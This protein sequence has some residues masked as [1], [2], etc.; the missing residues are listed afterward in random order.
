M[1]VSFAIVLTL[2]LFAPLYPVAAQTGV[3]RLDVST[4]WTNYRMDQTQVS[5]LNTTLG[6]TATG[7]GFSPGYT[8]VLDQQNCPNGWFSW[9]DPFAHDLVATARGSLTL[10][11]TY[12]DVDWRE[13]DGAPATS[14][15]T[16]LSSSTGYGTPVSLLGYSYQ[17]EYQS[18]TTT[19]YYYFL[20]AAT[21]DGWFDVDNYPTVFEQNGQVVHRD[22]IVWTRPTISNELVPFLFKNDEGPNAVLI[23]EY[24]GRA[25]DPYVGSA[26]PDRTDIGAVVL[27]LPH[28]N[29]EAIYVAYV[30][31][32]PRTA[33]VQGTW[34]V[35]YEDGTYTQLT[36]DLQDWCLKSVAPDRYFPGPLWGPVIGGP[37]RVSVSGT[38]QDIWTHVYA[39]KI[40]VN[41]GKT[42]DELVLYLGGLRG[43]DVDCY[44]YMIA[45]TIETAPGQ[46]LLVTGPNTYYVVSQAQLL[47]LSVSIPS[48]TFDATTSSFQIPSMTFSVTRGENVYISTFNVSFYAVYA[49]TTYEPVDVTSY[50]TVNGSQITDTLLST[51][52]SAL[53]NQGYYTFQNVTVPLE[54]NQPPV[55]IVA[56]VK[57]QIVVNGTV[58][59]VVGV[60]REEVLFTQSPLV[61]VSATAYQTSWSYDNG[62]AECGLDVQVSWQL[63]TSVSAYV[64]SVSVLVVDSAG[65]VVAEKCEYTTDPETSPLQ[66]PLTISI[67]T[68]PDTPS[69]LGQLTVYVRVS[70]SYGY[71]YDLQPQTVTVRYLIP[72]VKAQTEISGQTAEVSGVTVDLSINL[73]QTQNPGSYFT[74]FQTQVIVGTTTLTPSLTDFSWSYDQTSGEWV[75]TYTWQPSSPIATNSISVTVNATGSDGISYTVTYTYPTTRLLTL[76][77]ISLGVSA[78]GGITGWV[79]LQV[80][81]SA[82]GTLSATVNGNPASLIEVSSGQYTPVSS[83]V[84]YSGS[85]VDVIIQVPVGDDMVYLKFQT[86]YGVQTYPIAIHVPSLT[87]S[88]DVYEVYYS[89]TGYLFYYSVSSQDSTMTVDLYDDGTVDASANALQG[90]TVTLTLEDVSSGASYSVTLQG[91]TGTFTVPPDTFPGP[92]GVLQYTVQV[93]SQYLESYDGTPTPLTYQDETPYSELSWTY[94]GYYITVFLDTINDVMVAQAVPEQDLSVKG[95]YYVSGVDWIYH[96]GDDLVLYEGSEGYDVVTVSAT[97][98]GSTVQVSLTPVTFTSYG[99]KETDVSSNTTVPVTVITIPYSGTTY[100]VDAWGS[101]TSTQ[102][103]TLTFGTTQTVSSAGPLVI[104]DGQPSYLA[105]PGGFASVPYAVD[106]M[107][108]TTP[109]SSS[110]VV[111]GAALASGSYSAFWVNVGAGVMTYLPV[112]GYQFSG[113]YYEKNASL[114]VLVFSSATSQLYL[115]VDTDGEFFEP[116]WTTSEYQWGGMEYENV[117]DEEV[118]PSN[119]GETVVVVVEAEGGTPVAA[120]LV[121]GSPVKPSSV[122]PSVPSYVLLVSTSS[123][124]VA[125]ELTPSSETWALPIQVENPSNLALPSMYLFPFSD[126]DILLTSTDGSSLYAFA[127]DAVKTVVTEALLTEVKD[128]NGTAYTLLSLKAGGWVACVLDVSNGVPT[129]LHPATAGPIA[130][131]SSYGT[132]YFSAVPLGTEVLFVALDDQGEGLNAY[133]FTGVQS[134]EVSAVGDRFV[135]AYEG[136]S[137]GWYAVV[138]DVSVTE[139]GPSFSPS[140]VGEVLGL[141]SG[142]AVATVVPGSGQGYYLVCLNGSTKEATAVFTSTDKPAVSVSASEVAFDSDGTL[143][144]YYVRSDGEPVKVYEDTGTSP[145]FCGDFLTYSSGGTEVVCYLYD[146]NGDGVDEV[147]KEAGCVDGVYVIPYV[148]NPSGPTLSVTFA[149]LVDGTPMELSLAELP[150]GVDVVQVSPSQGVAYEVVIAEPRTG[151]WYLVVYGGS[152]TLGFSLYLAEYVHRAFVDYSFV[153]FDTVSG[154]SSTTHVYSI[155][156][157]GPTEVISVPGSLVDD[158]SES[159]FHVLVL[160]TGSGY[161]ALV[162]TPLGVYEPINSVEVGGYTFEIF[163]AEVEGES[164]PVSEVMVI[165]IS[166]DGSVSLVGEVE[167]GVRLSRGGVVVTSSNEYVLVTPEGVVITKEGLPVAGLFVAEENGEVLLLRYSQDGVFEGETV[168]GEGE[169]SGFQVCYVRDEPVAVVSINK[170]EEVLAVTESGVLKPLER[171]DDEAVFVVDGVPVVAFLGSDGSVE[172]V[173]VELGNASSGSS[174]S[175]SS[176]TQTPVSFPSPLLPLPLVP[177]VRRGCRGSRSSS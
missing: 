58:I 119:G 62:T 146:Y 46:F 141:S 43:Q 97:T 126:G 78:S 6:L 123:G 16:L 105:L 176:S 162:V 95:R 140:S 137:G 28:V 55:T 167:G 134:Y 88:C 76:S 45:L 102:A 48:Y 159:G 149:E 60:S 114:A 32:G 51:V 132:V 171:E 26:G 66:P 21:D 61:S 124:M 164:G 81:P 77:V 155:Q 170:G 115:V 116:S 91:T 128:Q 172:R 63:N 135:L 152:Q 144:V 20:P 50:V 121:P 71:V 3:T 56:E 166:S 25:E 129:G 99:L 138:I 1:R 173:F 175:S 103:T 165:R 110:S 168:L 82:D 52:A 85:P 177:G 64:N 154:S 49:S 39:V 34:Y 36:I 139:N 17:Y 69:N 174:S 150:F 11:A 57:G 133:A 70:C 100:V 30:C 5:Q 122:G 156:T 68:S 33:I 29:A 147:F 22:T 87:L 131:S 161:S 53:Q 169:I 118:Y 94:P 111:V 35:I 93:E 145:A 158:V 130:V 148:G 89:S 86:S 117:I 40:P 2:L 108:G 83:M 47:S 109:S 127:P 96:P 7:Q 24:H 15:S 120:Y 9:T 151:P 23:A 160:S 13:S 98:S 90:A 92:Y 143:Y 107:T 136:S 113:G 54:G 163:D 59:G 31:A 37:T 75:G 79:E 27:E 72:S 38:V 65:N 10:L 4:V 142:G 44:V 112:S 67:T 125:F 41:P 104:V 153:A 74:S 84:L 80:S 106:M 12:N 8:Y 157:T 73:P 18:G 101:G 14:A 42:L 19:T